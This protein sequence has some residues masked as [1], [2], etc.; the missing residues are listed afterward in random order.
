MRSFRFRNTFFAHQSPEELDK[1]YERLMEE[2]F[3]LHYHGRYNLL[4]QNQ[5]TAEDR[6]WHL[7]RVIKQ[8]DDER[9]AAEKNNR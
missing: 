8:L 6:A 3:Q 2:Q 7:K 1:N 5:M 4:I 9:Q